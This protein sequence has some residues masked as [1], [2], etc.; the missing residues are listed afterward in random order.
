MD[1]GPSL[2][3]ERS[4]AFISIQLPNALWMENFVEEC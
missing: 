1:Y 4:N 2:K 3:W